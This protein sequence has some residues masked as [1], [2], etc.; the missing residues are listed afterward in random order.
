MDLQTMKKY[1]NQALESKPNE[2]VLFQTAN[3]L[4]EAIKEIERLQTKESTDE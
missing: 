4:Y 2:K 1:L 3:A